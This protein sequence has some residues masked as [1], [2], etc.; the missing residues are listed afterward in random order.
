MEI[1]YNLIRKKLKNITIKIVSDSLIEVHAPE[2]IT[3]KKIEKIINKKKFWIYKNIKKIPKK[4][5][6]SKEY[7]SGELFWYLGKKFRLDITKTNHKGLEFKYSKFVLN[8]NDKYKAKELFEKF[9]KEKAKEKIIPRVYQYANK[10]GLSVNEVK[11]REM[12][13][14][15]GTCTLQSNIILNYHLIKAPW[16]VIDYV[17]I[18]E[19]AHLIEFSHNKKFWQIVKM[20]MPYYKKA[21]EWLRDNDIF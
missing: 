6:N 21:Q 15:W 17:I 3:D 13:K 7:I 1:Q 12:K 18:H 10:M 19:L 8:V 16:S 2:E 4:E 11:I 20:Q 9:Y 14:R 5:S